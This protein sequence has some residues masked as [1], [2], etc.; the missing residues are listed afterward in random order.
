MK[1]RLD[2]L[3]RPRSVAI[4]GASNRPDSM[5][6]W[7]LKNLGL[8]SYPG[9][10]YPVNPRYETLQG[11]RCFKTIDALPETPDLV[12]FAVG[13]ERLEAA[14]DEAIAAGIPAAVI[15]SPLAIDNDSAP[16]LRQRVRQKISAAGMLVCGAN[17]MGYYNVRDHVWTC[18]FD[19]SPHAAPGNVAL[20]SHSG[21]GM[22]GII[23]CEERLRIN[24]AVS[25]GNE[26]GVTMDEYLDFVLDL[27]ETRVVGLFIETAR[28]PDGFRAALLKAEQRRIPVVALKVGRTE[29]SAQLSVSHSGVMAGVDATYEALFDR[30]GVQRARDQD[31]FATM[32]IMFAELHPVG[33]GGLVA[34]HDSGGER[35]LLVDLAHDAGVSMTKL[36]EQTVSA[37]EAI[38]DPELP[39]VNPL[40]AWSRGG[41]DAGEVMTRSLSLMMQDAGAA[42][43][44][45]IHDRGPGGKIY[46]SYVNYMQ[47]ARSET[48]KPVALVAARQGTGCDEVVVAS[49][50]AGFPVLDGVSAFLS[51][52]HA[53]FAYRDF[54][55]RKPARPIR[56]EAAIVRKW[57][58]RLRS[59]GS[60][61]ESMS[62]SLL[63]DF[64]IEASK[65]EV[66]NNEQQ[67]LAVAKRIG[68]PL[69]LK[70]AKAGLVHKSDLGG[71]ILG[72]GSEEQ[73]QQMYQ[74]LSH[75]LGPDVL[76]ASMAP[77]GV[78][79][80]LGIKRDP[81]FG[82][83]VLL[84]F[85]G[86]LAETI[87]DVQFALPPFDAAHARRCLDRMQFRPLLDG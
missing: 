35:Q 79:M 32:L 21:S 37:L 69:S 67:V 22:S 52:V 17:G 25:T 34:L 38:L 27:P 13:D 18:G 31:E 6:E 50:H 4:V 86:V 72:I 30:Y 7:V 65:A 60:L 56:S 85:G 29:M 49:T 77:A 41:A 40:D 84:G 53:L 9:D 16:D 45:V 83:V 62:L 28:D 33:A 43:G 39:A 58:D 11:H 24:V 55:L 82:P 15:Q 14:L 76:L 47:R 3:L 57:Q 48:D 23:D 8:G 73:L 71:V 2:P 54:L 44:A 36:S 26:I 61:S 75:R 19:S 42:L 80:F 68:Y 64:G 5:G 51:G 59:G 74:I 70:T 20:I 63:D 87:N 46:P 78:E 1:H 81:Q 10:I 12:V 66:A